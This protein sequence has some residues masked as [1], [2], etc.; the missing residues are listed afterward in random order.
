MKQIVIPLILVAAFI[1]A[2]GLFTTKSSKFNLLPSPAPKGDQVQIGDKSITVEIADSFEERGKGLSGRTTLKEDAGMLFIFEKKDVFPSFW[3]KDT[4]IA[5]DLIWINDAKV[6][7]I[8]KNVQ[9]EPGKTD[10]EL[11]LYRPETPIDYVIEVSGGFSD[12]FG[13]KVGD[14]VSGI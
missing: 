4:L 12:K 8:H 11:T 7:K 2:V 5:L 1:I 10:A 6:V 9:P 14:S 3:M 13:V